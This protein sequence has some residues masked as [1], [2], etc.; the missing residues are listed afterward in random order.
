QIEDTGAKDRAEAHPP[1]GD[2]PVRQRPIGARIEL[3]SGIGA[4]P[5]VERNFRADPAAQAE[6]ARRVEQAVASII[7]EAK[8]KCRDQECTRVLDS[9]GVEDA[10]FVRR[11]DLAAIGPGPFLLPDEIALPLDIAGD[12]D[13]SRLIGIE[14]AVRGGGLEVQYLVPLQEIAS[15]KLDAE[16]L[17]AGAGDP[18][19]GQRAFGVEEIAVRPARFEPGALA[20]SIA[21][22]TRDGVRRGRLETDVEIHRPAIVLRRYS[23][24]RCGNEAGRDQGPA[25]I[26]DLRSLEP[27]ARL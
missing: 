19:Q 17:L 11:Q 22:L 1:G 23:N 5:A 24:L 6:S 21:E 2:D 18:A 20:S 27:L 8:G 12:L 14:L 26:V 7:S 10:A 16:E 25:Q 4:P 13:R 9:G 15:T 3:D